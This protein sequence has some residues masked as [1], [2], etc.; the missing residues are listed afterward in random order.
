MKFSR[1]SGSAKRS[2]HSLIL[3]DSCLTPFSRICRVGR[4]G[5][6]ETNPPL[7][8][9]HMAGDRPASW[10]VFHANQDAV[11]SKR[12]KRNPPSGGYARLVA[13]N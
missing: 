5:K 7:V 9:F 6:L 13:L 11:P 2:S 8:G 3:S 4:G 10:F 12:E 1:K